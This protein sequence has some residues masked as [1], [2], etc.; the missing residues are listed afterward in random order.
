MAKADVLYQTMSNGFRTDLW[1]SSRRCDQKVMP[2]W[3][4]CQRLTGSSVVY[5]DPYMNGGY[6]RSRHPP[7]ATWTA[8]VTVHLEVSLILPE[9]ALRLAYLQ[10]SVQLAQSDASSLHIHRH[11]P[12]P[13]G[14]YLRPI[15]TLRQLLDHMAAQAPQGGRPEAAIRHMIPLTISLFPQM[16]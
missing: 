2:T 9:Q 14:R 3:S 4:T 10:L 11:Q 15:V 8:E 7:F 1:N 16:A 13:R 5:D 6:H 12:T